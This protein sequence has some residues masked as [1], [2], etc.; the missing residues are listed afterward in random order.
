VTFLRAWAPILVVTAWLVAL[1]VGLALWLATIPAVV[2]GVYVTRR[3]Y[4]PEMCEWR[5]YGHPRNRRRE[6]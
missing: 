4:I 2:V 6:P 5:L 1:I 3:F